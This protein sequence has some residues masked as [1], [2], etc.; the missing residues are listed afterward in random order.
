M[1]EESIVIDIK[2]SVGSQMME[3]VKSRRMVFVAG[4]PSSGKSFILQQL[5][6]MAGSAG[7]NVYSLQWDDA[8]RSFE[9]ETALA[10][11]PEVDNL[12][13]PAI[14][15]AVGYWVRSAVV[16][17]HHANP[18]PANILIVEL[19][20]MGGRFVELM[21][22]QNDEAEALLA[23][24]Q[25]ILFTPIPTVEVRTAIE[26]VRQQTIDNPRHE[27]EAKDAPL[28]IVQ[29]EWQSIRQIYNQQKNIEPDAKRDSLYDPDVYQEVFEKLLRFRKSAILHID[30]LYEVKGS[31]YE[32]PVP[33]EVIEAQAQD[34]T[35]SYE[36]LDREFPA[37]KAERAIDDWANY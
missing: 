35:A 26:A 4:L 15:K 10:R 16:K 17:W 30:Q 25:I 20:V 18:D 34:I 12:T 31:A 28:Y 11:F 24:D 5:T 36:R 19:P 7:R 6:I 22:P 29:A 32:R 2:S 1:L 23:S 37:E 3:A 14:R 13:H 8:R 33:V 27:L 9:T 21:Q